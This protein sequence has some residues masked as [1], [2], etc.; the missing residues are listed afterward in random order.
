MPP[1]LYIASQKECI[2]ELLCEKFRI[3]RSE[4]PV[5]FYPE[6]NCISMKRFLSVPAV[7]LVFLGTV[8]AQMSDVSNQGAQGTSQAG[9]TL[10]AISVPAAGIIGAQS[11]LLGGIPTGEATAEALPLSLSEAL[12]R[13]LKYNLGSFLSEQSVQATR[14]ARLLALSQL[15]PRVTAGLNE[16]QEQVNLAAFGFKPSPG[17]KTVVGPFNVF[18]VRAYVTQPVLDFVARNRYH[19]S[20]EDVKAAQFDNVN[21]RDMVAFVCA[22]LYLQAVASSSRIDATR[23]Q[24][25]TA[26]VLYDL[27]LD[28]KAAGVSPG[29]EVL[30]AQVEL[31]AQRQR[32]IVA[33]DQ[34][35][36]DKL[37]LARAIGLPLGQEFTLTDGMSYSPLSS[38]SLDETVQRAYKER[39]DLQSAQARVQSAESQRK[40]AQRRASSDAQFQCRLW[41]YRAAAMGIPRHLHRG[42][43]SAHSS[44]SGRKRSRSRFGG[45]RRLA[46]AQS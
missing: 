26:Q 7:M 42:H 38:M 45:G 19:A 9:Q 33:E 12:K 22:N 15:L 14:G 10:S 13:G 1:L 30:R 20:T 39:P 31:Q 23:A 43:H 2:I 17:M 6:R 8:S 24:V 27:A 40:A 21:T 35:A 25:R 34:F 18:D 41:R 28:Q 36:K 44:F 37:A 5:C 46:A 32:L 4:L 29:I 16:Q 11:P 3:I